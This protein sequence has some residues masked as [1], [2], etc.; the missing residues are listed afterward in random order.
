MQRTR[1][2]RQDRA[3]SIH[4][5]GPAFQAEISVVQ[6]QIQMRAESLWQFPI[7]FEAAEP[8]APTVEMPLPIRLAPL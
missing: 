2:G 6:G 1:L 8:S 5:E 4:A 3:L 7:L